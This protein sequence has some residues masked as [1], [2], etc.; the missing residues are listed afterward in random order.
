[1]KHP[2]IG[3]H[4]LLAVGRTVGGLYLL[5]G[6]KGAPL[7]LADGHIIEGNLR[8]DLSVHEDIVAIEGKVA[9]V[10]GV[11][12]IV[13]ELFP[14]LPSDC[15]EG[16]LPRVNFSSEGAPTIWPGNVR[17]VVSKLKKDF[18][19]FVLYEKAALRSRFSHYPLLYADQVHPV[20]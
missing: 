8:H 18:P 20:Q 3:Y 19:L 10:L 7:P 5:Q 11:M 13:H 1:M 14:D 17:P 9:E 4:N 15:L 2:V 12:E 16:A 6:E